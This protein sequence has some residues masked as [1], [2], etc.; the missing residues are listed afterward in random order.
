MRAALPRGLQNVPVVAMER[1]QRDLRVWHTA[2]VPKY[3]DSARERREEVPA[4]VRILQGDVW[5]GD[6]FACISAL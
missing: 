6:V 2:T 5:F 4:T 1:V 3:P